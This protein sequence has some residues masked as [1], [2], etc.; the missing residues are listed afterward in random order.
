MISF[1]FMNGS[2]LFQGF[3]FL[4]HACVAVLVLVGYKT[5]FFKFVL[6]AFYV[7]LP[8]VVVFWGWGG[9]IKDGRGASENSWLVMLASTLEN[10]LMPADSHADIAAQSPSACAEWWR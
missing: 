5:T 10:L 3:L 4:V 6:Y 9:Q 2:S 8:I 7:C 1:H